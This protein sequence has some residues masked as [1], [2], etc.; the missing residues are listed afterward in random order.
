MS[1]PIRVLV[2]DD[3]PLFRQ[4]L[5]TLVDDAETLELV[6]EADSGPAAV[7]QATA[8]APDLVLMDLHLPGFDGVEATRRIVAAVPGIRVL[9]LT[10]AD[11]TSSVQA[12]LRAGAAGYTLKGAP[13]REIMQAISA[14][15]AGMSV[16]SADVTGALTAALANAPT[17]VFPE[18]TAREHD[19]LAL[20]GAGHGNSM[21]AKRL[22]L[23]E[24]TV[25]N[26]V[27]AILA[28]LHVADRTTA[29]E[30][31]RAAGL[32]G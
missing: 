5:R 2:V 12:A 18:L 20:V 8:R 28:K 9:V 10:M 29:G 3:H 7:E 21:I 30:R 25:R 22:G 6:G 32:V 31:A 24:K 11:D 19:V 23:S 4:G 16:F 1:Q 13:P 27:S 15:A 17:A 14:V 26:M